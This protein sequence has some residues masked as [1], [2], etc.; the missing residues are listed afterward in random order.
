M[1]YYQV[2]LVSKSGINVSKIL[3]TEEALDQYIRYDLKQECYVQ[4]FV[5]GLCVDS[6]HIT[7]DKLREFRK[8][9]WIGICFI[10]CGVLLFNLYRL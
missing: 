1:N 3:Y 7:K 8:H 6:F 10:V 2:M 9:D 4:K 5:G